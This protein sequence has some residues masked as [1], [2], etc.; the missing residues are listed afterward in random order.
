[1]KNT[2]A[3]YEGGCVVYTFAGTGQ[4]G[5]RDGAK[6][7][8]QFNDP[9][10]IA[11]DTNGDLYVAD[12]GNHR[13]RKITVAHGTVHTVAGTG[14]PGCKDGP[15]RDAR[16]EGPYGIAIGAKDTII[17]TDSSATALRA[18]SPSA[19][20]VMPI[21]G[22]PTGDF[23][24]P[25]GVAVTP[26]GNI[27]V[28][29]TGKGRIVTL[30]AHGGAIQRVVGRGEHGYANGKAA[31]AQLSFPWAI[32]ASPSGDLYVADSGNHCIRKID[33]RS[34]VVSTVAGTGEPGW[35]DGDARTAQFNDPHGIAV[36]AD[37]CIYVSEARNHCVRK[38]DPVNQRVVTVAGEGEKGFCDGDG[39]MARFNDPDG[40]AF[41]HDGVLYVVDSQNDRIR[42]IVYK[43]ESTLETIKIE[44]EEHEQQKNELMRD[45]ESATASTIASDKDLQKT[46]NG[47]ALEKE[48]LATL[49]DSVNVTRV[50][51]CAAVEHQ[52]AR[53]QKVKNDV[54]DMENTKVLRVAENARVEAAL[55]DAQ[56]VRNTVLDEKAQYAQELAV[57]DAH[58]QSALGGHRV[59]HGNIRVVRDVAAR[60]VEDT[61]SDKGSHTTD[62]NIGVDDDPNEARSEPSELAGETTGSEHNPTQDNPPD[63]SLL[64][65]QLLTLFEEEEDDLDDPV[66]CGK[67]RLQVL[68]KDYAALLHDLGIMNAAI[69]GAQHA[70]EQVILTKEKART[71]K[72]MA[73]H[74]RVDCPVRQKRRK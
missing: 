20:T 22:T 52:K 8:A 4:E 6:R 44:L 55:T 24:L 54:R 16:F 65:T 59:D 46:K 34:G 36:A 49:K 29:D 33:A 23:L 3:I 17:V 19:N 60:R 47:I 12:A 37:G 64:Q 45:I 74:T 38:V 40:L 32:A 11:V 26:D 48:H 14:I 35:R 53:L 61:K 5:H 51:L 27:H 67:E 69:L 70:F 42:A 25:T 13:L 18:F 66:Q 58:L 7:N 63:T 73:E 2:N 43:P 50:A 41:G 56:L 21:A 57:L 72:A 1:M 62:T 10:S 15:A 30:R 71:Q 68:G 39:G 28:C 9:T 31:K